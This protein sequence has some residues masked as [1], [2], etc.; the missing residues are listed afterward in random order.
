MTRVSYNRLIDSLTSSTGLKLL[1][2][3]VTGITF[4]TMW[5]STRWNCTMWILDNNPCIHCTVIGTMR[6]VMITMH[7]V[8]SVGWSEIHLISGNK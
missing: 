8:V 7:N 4:S 3:F 2:T 6:N 1:G 5:I